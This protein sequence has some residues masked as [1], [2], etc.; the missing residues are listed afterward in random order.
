MSR[1]SLMLLIVL[2]LVASVLA[3][4]SKSIT[5]GSAGSVEVA[6]VEHMRSKHAESARGG[7]QFCVLV[8]PTGICWSPS[9]LG[10]YD[11]TQLANS[12]FCL[13]SSGKI[14]NRYYWNQCLAV[15]APGGSSNTTYPASNCYSGID[16]CF[17]LYDCEY[18]CMNNGLGDWQ[19]VR[20]ALPTTPSPEFT[21]GI[22]TDDSL[23]CTLD[24][25]VM[26]SIMPQRNVIAIAFP[27]F[28]TEM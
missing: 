9:P 22:P 20:F 17:Q 8:Y 18:E 19:C 7:N 2:A 5:V 4:T 10:C 1:I 11:C 26:G 12:R 13:N 3:T 28:V 27:S 21:E 15:D 23:P 24:P 16:F 6:D 14:R 25:P